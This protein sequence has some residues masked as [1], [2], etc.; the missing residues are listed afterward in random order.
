MFTPEMLASAKKVEA[1]RAQR[2]GMEPK[3]MTAEE[4]HNLLREFHPD[5]KTDGFEN[6]KIGPNKG[7]KVPKELAALLQANSRV[8][9]LD[10][11]LG[12][13][14][15]DVDVLIIG[16]G[17]AGASA[18]IE[19]AGG[20]A[21]V[22]VV[23]KLRMGDANT[24][25]AEGGIQAADKAN[26]SPAIHYLDALG[27]G[28]YAN[29]PDLLKKLVT[30]GP[31][32]VKWLNDL[33]VML[34]KA[35]DGTMITTHGGGTSRKRM[36]AARDYSGAEIM[37]VLRDE[38][39]NRGIPVV[40]FTA[41]V[42]LILDENGRAAGAVLQNMETG[43]YLVAR[44]KTVILATGGAGR[45]H[46]QGFPTSNHYGATADGLILAYRAGAKLLYQDTLQ[47]HPTGAAFPE[48]IF[49]ALVTEKVR[50]LG[51]MLINSEGEAF[52]HPLE[53]RDVAAAS[54]IRECKARKKGIPT[55]EGCGVWLDTPM[56]D[57]IHGEGTLE[58]R[59]PA[60]LRMYM[61]YDIDM[62]EVPILVYPTLHYQNGGVDISVDG[63]SGV[64]NLFI[65]GEAVGGIHGRNRLMGNSLLDIIVFGRNAGKNAAAKAKNVKGGKL[66]LR[67]VEAYA[68]EMAD[69]G[70]VSDKVS[71]LLLP[72]YTHGR[73]KW[74]AEK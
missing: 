17:G 63:Q 62:R 43:E 36:H 52:M 20:G 51:A 73:E 12:R 21:N 24:M 15:Y 67:H 60:M 61:K 7:E 11:D 59:I 74:Q 40:D 32:A 29:K 47:Y 41:A 48:Q 22:M 64:E 16:G 1:T 53:T 8:K 14:A 34:D 71:P 72:T 65:A 42:E 31:G 66:T 9:G 28:H 25:M 2:I 10:L 49:G 69:A 50:S 19:A 46:Y 18:A 37:R 13:I 4:K 5:Y 27:G 44:A 26:D 38:V 54:I 39:W 58:K 3:R 35:P 23:T 33:G 45:L 30:E 6:L 68:Q 56:I 55:P 70:I 57:M